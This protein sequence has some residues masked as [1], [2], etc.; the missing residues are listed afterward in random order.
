MPVFRFL[1][2][3]VSSGQDKTYQGVQ[4]H[5]FRQKKSRLS[6]GIRSLKH[7]V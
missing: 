2:G 3:S 7:V 1:A 4:S 5:R 6:G